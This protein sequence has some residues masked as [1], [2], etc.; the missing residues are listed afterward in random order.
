M[1]PPPKLVN[2]SSFSL[3]GTSGVGPI[4]PFIIPEPSPMA[5]GVM[6]AIILASSIRQKSIDWIPFFDF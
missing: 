4:G 1:T 3:S 5:M 6:G 2:L